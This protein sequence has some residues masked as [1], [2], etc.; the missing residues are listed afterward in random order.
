M[1]RVLCGSSW[2]GSSWFGP[3]CPA[4]GVIMWS[5]LIVGI[6]NQLQQWGQPVCKEH[7]DIDNGIL[8]CVEYYAACNISQVRLL[9]RI[10][11]QE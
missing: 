10:D 4:P 2:H 7:I 9:L 5:M 11:K 8:F 1:G 3:S 6:I